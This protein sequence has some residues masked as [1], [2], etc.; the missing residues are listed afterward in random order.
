MLVVV[1]AKLAAAMAA[2][3]PMLHQEVLCPPRTALLITGVS[4]EAQH[5]TNC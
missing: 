1:L 5:C 4:I 3:R 2:A